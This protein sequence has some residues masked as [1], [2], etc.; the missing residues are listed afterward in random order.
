VLLAAYSKVLVTLVT[1][2][3][4]FIATSNKTARKISANVYIDK[5]QLESELLHTDVNVTVDVSDS[6]KNLVKEVRR[7]AVQSHDPICSVT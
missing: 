7:A 5:A 3:L 2:S 6:E 1:S 4:H